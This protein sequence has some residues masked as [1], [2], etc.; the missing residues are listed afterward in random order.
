MFA[1]NFG[2]EYSTFVYPGYPS[3]VVGW[4]GIGCGWVDSGALK[5]G[6]TVRGAAASLA[7]PRSVQSKH[8]IASSLNGQYAISMCKHWQVG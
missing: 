2:L 3:H 8:I 7:V 4:D 6:A 1:L 5:P